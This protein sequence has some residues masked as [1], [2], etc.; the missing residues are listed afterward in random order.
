MGGAL[1]GAG[2]PHDDCDLRRSELCLSPWS[3]G[4][5]GCGGLGE[6]VTL[7]RICQAVWTFKLWPTDLALLCLYMKGQM[8]LCSL[9]R[10]GR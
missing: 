10:L 8:G 9:W 6:G 4:F 7:L 2:R 5:G 1:P 3:R